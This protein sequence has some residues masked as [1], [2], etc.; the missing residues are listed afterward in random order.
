VATNRLINLGPAP[1]AFLF[2]LPMTREEAFAFSA[3]E[4]GNDTREQREM[5][6]AWKVKMT[7]AHGTWVG[8]QLGRIKLETRS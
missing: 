8:D 2:G 6:V 4:A 3:F 5:L 1:V 7:L